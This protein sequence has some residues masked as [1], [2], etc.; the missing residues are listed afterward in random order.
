MSVR[1]Q[2]YVFAASFLLP[3]VILY[4]VFVL[5]PAVQGLEISFY[6]WSGL[7]MNRTWVGLA[8]FE[9]F[10]RELT[11]P[12]DFFNIRNYLG[13]NIFIFCFGLASIFIGLICAALIHAKPRGANLFR[14]TYFFPRVLAIPAIA[15]LW[16][17]V[18]HPDYGLVNSGLRA[19]G[20][21]AWA[22][23]W[24]S[25]QEE[26]P[27]QRLGVWTMGFVGIWAALGWYMILFLAT[28]QNVPAEFT[29]AALIDG[30]T[31][32]QTFFLIVI[33]LIWETLRTTIVFAVMG[34]FFVFDLAFI[35]FEQNANKNS[36]MIAHY[37]YWQ[38]FGANNW[39]YSSAIVTV[40]FLV[41]I[42]LTIG[43]FFALKRESVQY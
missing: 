43:T 24:W 10:F 26:M 29:E 22:K 6:K 5:Y 9:R 37:Y 7:S 17:M 40:M 38:A 32:G 25:L 36:D 30:A 27:F 20:L 15:L 2:R 39:G 1:T 18:L 3:A 12:N 23:P 41:T 11:A 8:N 31:K 28:I 42:V 4:T 33:P 16:S 35:L 13:R 19:I 21:E 14:V 34:M